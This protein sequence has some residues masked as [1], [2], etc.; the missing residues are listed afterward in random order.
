MATIVYATGDD[1]AK[2]SSRRAGSSAAAAAAAAAAGAAAENSSFLGRTNAFVDR[3][4]AEPELVATFLILC[5]N[6]VLATAVFAFQAPGIIER[7]YTVEL[8]ALNSRD[9][10]T[11]VVLLLVYI[12]FEMVSL[13]VIITVVLMLIRQ[14][15][16][17]LVIN[18]NNVSNMKNRLLL[19]VP[20]TR[21]AAALI[22]SGLLCYCVAEAQMLVDMGV[23]VIDAEL[24]AMAGL[25]N[26][27]TRR[28]NLG[29]TPTMWYL[30][31]LSVLAL[32]ITQP[33]MVWGLHKLAMKL[34]AKDTKQLLLGTIW[35][36]GVLYILCMLT[37]RG[38]F[39]TEKPTLFHQVC[40]CVCVMCVIVM[41]VICVCVCVCYV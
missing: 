4:L 2:P 6:A 34:R 41:G 3:W 14:C 11:H 23:H 32:A 8:R 33:L 24:L 31:N 12:A 21:T 20:W 30:I 19:C 1:D 38:F 28:R 26:T 40:V 15:M 9:F 13:C 27:I 7:Y 16:L 25:S 10:A 39:L 29:L 5:V 22:G 37:A 17:R 36:W 35:T 18:S